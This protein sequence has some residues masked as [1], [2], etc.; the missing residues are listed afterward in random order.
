MCLIP[1]FIEYLIILFDKV[2]H[3]FL[4]VFGLNKFYLYTLYIEQHIDHIIV[5]EA[6][7]TLSQGII[8][9]PNEI[10][11]HCDTYVH[12]PFEYPLHDTFTRNVWI[13]KD[14]N[15][16][17]FNKKISDFDWSCLHQGTVNEA[18]SL[19]TNIFIEFAKLCI[20]SKTIVVRVDDK[21]WYDSEIR[22]N[23]RKRDRLKKTALKSGNQYDWKKYKYYRNKVNNKKKW[24]QSFLNVCDF[25]V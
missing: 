23:S 18:S 25:S 14:A 9:V 16:E 10:S 8:Q 2:I 12:I 7:S 22:R 5:H 6:M 13:Y 11:D 19:F 24:F 21:P 4:K 1:N 20:P 15:Y 17:L 3:Y